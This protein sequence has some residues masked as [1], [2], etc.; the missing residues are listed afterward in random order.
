MADAFDRASVATFFVPD[1][2]LVP[3]G[4]VTLGEELMHHVRVLRLGVGAP[5]S[6]LD[7]QG[8]RATGTLVRMSRAAGIVEVEHST[9]VPAA[10][11]VHLIVPIAD[12]ERMMWL[13][14]KS[15]ELAATSWRPVL[16]RRSRSVKPRG[17]GPTFTGKVRARM[18]SAL[19]QSGGAWL[20]ALYPEA[21]IARAIAALPQKGTRIVLDPHGPPILE[22]EVTAPVT[23]AIGP[24][25]GFEGEEVDELVNAGFQRAALGGNILRFE[26]AAVAA[27][28]IARSALYPRKPAH[29][30]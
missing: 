30:A 11:A 20:P 27:L 10:P 2:T 19:E 12:R 1:E 28:A 21:T 17:E 13:A 26:T 3:G 23:I 29:G 9:E 7:G 14:E 5:V 16:F 4:A 8:H 22:L 25:G 18:G 6:L 24:E 15:A